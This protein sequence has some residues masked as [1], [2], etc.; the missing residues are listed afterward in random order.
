MTDI[1]RVFL[2]GRLTRDAELRFTSSGTPVAKFSVAVNRGKKSGDQWD[3]EVNYF[4]IVLWG[5]VAEALSKY[6]AKGKQ[7][8]IDGEL[9]QSRWEQDGQN[10]SRVEIH[11]ANIQLLGGSGAGGGNAQSSA[12]SNGSGNNF[13][14]QERSQ[15]QPQGKSV[16]FEK[17]EK[18]SFEEPGQFDDDGIPF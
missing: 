7:V 4:D 16:P 14:R 8:A 9:R 18:E 15:M 3:E 13:S 6:L 11:A 17:Y 5:K 2:V 12:Q 10:R 1:N